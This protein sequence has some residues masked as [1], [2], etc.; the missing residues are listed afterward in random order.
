M[1][2][3][4][5]W[6]A[7]GLR[8]VTLRRMFGMFDKS[9]DCDSRDAP[10]KDPCLLDD[11]PCDPCPSSTSSPCPPEPPTYHPHADPCKF[12]LWRTLSLYVALP[13]VVIMSAVTYIRQREK[14]KEPREPYL[15]LPY[16]CR[17]TK[18]FPWGDGNHTLFH[19]PLKNPVPPHGYEVEDPNEAS[20]KI[21]N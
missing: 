8:S 18:P 13:L 21:G 7:A 12:A 6:R 2:L 1:P 11:D 20:K 14:A 5:V 9:R 15:N 3:I 4:R 16:M 10:E 19:N 17:R